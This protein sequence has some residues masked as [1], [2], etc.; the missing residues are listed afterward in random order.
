M[1]WIEYIFCLFLLISNVNLI[2]R[3]YNN[4][5]QGQSFSSSI[6]LPRTTTDLKCIR[7]Q[8]LFTTIKRTIFFFLL[9]QTNWWDLRIYTQDVGD[10]SAGIQLS[11]S[12]CYEIKLLND[13]K[14]RDEQQSYFS[15]L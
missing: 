6:L 4:K 13:S 9:N 1:Y 11:F 10:S 8:T 7:A 15:L 14:I 2:H 12:I 5:Y 3:E